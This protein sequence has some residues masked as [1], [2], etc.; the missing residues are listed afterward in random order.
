MV[1]R[2]VKLYL[3]GV[4]ISS[5][6]QWSHA[7]NTVVI[8]PGHGGND[9]GAVRG[10]IYEKHLCLDVAKRL[11]DLLQEQGLRTIMTRRT[12]KTLSL[13]Q[14]ARMANRYRSAVFVSVHFNASHTRSASGMETLYLSRRGRIL[15]N[16]IQNSMGQRLPGKDRG[17]NAENLKVL[18]ETRCAAVLV[19]C[20]FISNRKEA[21]S[22]TSAAHRQKIANSIAKGIYSVRKKL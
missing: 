5:I 22:C 7:F 12:D 2:S 4:I 17:T 9:P 21:A 11:E 10:R 15:A 20:G 6:S 1:T 3:L 18:R 19:E 16:A 14:R 13:S 8:D